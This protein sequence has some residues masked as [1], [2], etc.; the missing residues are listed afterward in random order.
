MKIIKNKKIGVNR[1]VPRL[2]IE[3]KML[4]DH[5]WLR[6]VNFELIID[7]DYI[8]IIRSTEG[9]YTVAG[10]DKRPII[11]L[12]NKLLPDGQNKTYIMTV[13]YQSITLELNE[14]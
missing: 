2:W 6:G 1:G 14:V 5:D 7:G 13:E 10:N 9:G 8:T 12:N 4:T 11:D 3:G